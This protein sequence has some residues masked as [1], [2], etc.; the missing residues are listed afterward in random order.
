MVGYIFRY[1]WP[2][3]LFPNVGDQQR[4]HQSRHCPWRLHNRFSRQQDHGICENCDSDRG[5]PP[6]N[7]ACPFYRDC[8]LVY[9]Y[10]VAHD[11]DIFRLL[12]DPPTIIIIIFF[13]RKIVFIFV[14]LSGAVLYF[15]HCPAEVGFGFL[16]L[17]RCL[18]SAIAPASK[19]Q[20]RVSCSFSALSACECATACCM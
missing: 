1:V 4:D 3:L 12:G 14:V 9:F 6:T 20:R 8:V 19:H 11:R 13:H 18:P 15:V 10:Y 16:F 17:F 7:T 2:Q 5:H